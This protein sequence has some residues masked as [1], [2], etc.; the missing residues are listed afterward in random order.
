MAGNSPI[1]MV[2]EGWSLSTLG[3]T[4]RASGGNIQTGPFGSQLHAADYVPEGI[5]VVM[6]QDIGDNRIV[7]A[8]IARIQKKDAERLNRHR[9]E[10]GDI[11]Y[12]RRGDV[13]RRARV[14]EDNTGWLCGTGCLRVR[15][16]DKAVDAA[17]VSYYLGHP[18][19]QEWIFRHAVG[20][21]MPNLNTGILSAVPV[22]LPPLPE[23]R[24]IAAVL[25]AL[26]D[27]IELN[28]RM[29]RALEALAAALFRAWF[30]DFEPVSAKAEGRP[31]V[32]IDAA[33]A[34]LFPDRLVPS[35]T[36]GIPEGWTV[37][38]VGDVAEI[39]GWT[40]RRSDPLERIDYI[41]ISEVSRGDIA[42]ISRFARGTEPGRARRR[43]RHGDTAMSTVRPDRGS[44][45]LALEPSPELIASTG[46][47]VIT[48]TMAPWSFV[49]CSLIRPEIFGYLGQ[50]ADGSAYP[51]VP[52]EA[53]AALPIAYPSD[54]RILRAFHHLC[55]PLLS[56]EL[57][58]RQ[59]EAMVR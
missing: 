36:G 26:D 7:D 5:P 54:N 47:A 28:R 50:L 27:K 10:P 24:V 1:G 43:L 39:N 15:L 56:G 16:G 49:H 11:V 46:F 17:F 58:V 45:F 53:I 35:E 41:E 9:L 20:A 21:T 34:A 42:S 48:P 32:G 29:N 51:A 19:V 13:K 38:S 31:P 40:L 6:P 59:A 37:R 25:G 3:E 33:T 30:V 55:S 4:C 44:Y 2:P 8:A 18:A 14:R 22:A 23:Q 52:P 12:S 57:R